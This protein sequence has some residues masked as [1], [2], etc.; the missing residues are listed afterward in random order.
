MA[1]SK[2]LTNGLAWAGVALVIGVPVADWLAGRF[3]GEG[4]PQV[5][6]AQPETPTTAAAPATQPSPTQE[7]PQT[8]PATVAPTGD[9]DAVDNFV[10]SGRALPSYITGGDAPTTAPSAPANPAAST[11]APQIAA[12]P[13][14]PATT[15]PAATTPVAAPKIAPVPMPASMRPPSVELANQSPLIVPDRQVPV[16]VPP[17]QVPIVQPTRPSIT[18]PTVTAEDLD[19]WES[20]PLSEFLARRAQQNSG[21]FVEPEANSDGFFLDQ[22]PPE[23]YQGESFRRQPIFRDGY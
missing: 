22:A 10:R 17:A 1:L 2:K 3:E 23:L 6:I 13:S 14:A 11:P 4:A 20:G 7:A 8:A 5:A 9:G 15:P 19:D 16:V 18:A 12:V 21:Q